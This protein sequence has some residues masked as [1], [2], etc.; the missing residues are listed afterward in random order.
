MAAASASP[1]EGRCTSRPMSALTTRNLP[2]EVRGVVS[3]V[4]DGDERDEQHWHADHVVE[5]L[6]IGA[7][8]I[9]VYGEGAKDCAQYQYLFHTA[10]PQGA[11][12]QHL[13]QLPGQA[14]DDPVEDWKH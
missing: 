1:S 7:D 11:D 4:T 13:R 8:A 12:W 14:G 5:G 6:S 10:S 9:I 3:P 2:T